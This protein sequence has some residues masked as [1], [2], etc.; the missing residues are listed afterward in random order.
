MSKGYCAEENIVSVIMPTYNTKEEY[1][2]AAIESILNQSY[3]NFELIIVDD[4]S[5][6]NDWEII[7]EYAKRDTRITVAKNEQNKG[8]I[9]T[10]NRL[11]SMAS[12]YL[13][14]R[15]DSDDISHEKRLERTVKYF[16][17]N[18]EVDIV[19]GQYRTIIDR[20]KSITKTSLK[21]KDGDIK[22]YL[23]WQS[24][25]SHPSVCFKKGVVSEYFSDEKA[26]DYNL[27]TRLALKGFKFNNM[28][29]NLIYYRMHSE[30]ITQKL[31]DNMLKSNCSIHTKLFGELGIRISEKE[32]ELYELFANGL[33]DNKLDSLQEVDDIL[34]K[35]GCQMPDT[36]VDRNTLHKNINKKY[37]HE[38]LRMTRDCKVNT[39]KVY[40]GSKVSRFNRNRNLYTVFLHMVWFLAI[41]LR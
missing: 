29:Q 3:K 16:K 14:F 2:R 30:Q 13:I 35:I 33:L 38:C 5:T 21:R 37:F 10:L 36:Y 23:L 9:F 22:S 4:G 20:K 40:S 39:A 28:R 6:Q 11:I 19:G 41:F 17:C 7:N 1:L 27:W 34:V 18:P 31:S 25:M 8:L 26:E 32:Y 24:P 15:M 12:G